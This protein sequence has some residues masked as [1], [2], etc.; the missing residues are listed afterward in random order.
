MRCIFRRTLIPTNLL[1]YFLVWCRSA[2]PSPDGDP[3]TIPDLK[4][5]ISPRNFQPQMLN[6]PSCRLPIVKE[7]DVMLDVEIIWKVSLEGD[8]IFCDGLHA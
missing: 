5:G 7:E 2:E 6:S 1:D 3:S 8:E 4:Q